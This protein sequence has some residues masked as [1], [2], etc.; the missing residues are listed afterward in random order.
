[1]S[2]HFRLISSVA[3]QIAVFGMTRVDANVLSL[4]TSNLVLAT[5]L[6]T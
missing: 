6:K 5:E 4:D 2:F 1:M 3:N